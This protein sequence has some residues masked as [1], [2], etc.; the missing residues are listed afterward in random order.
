MNE[1]LEAY[2]NMQLKPLYRE[3][4]AEK[5]FIKEVTVHTL[6]SKNRSFKTE[7]LPVVKEFTKKF[8]QLE[9]KALN[10]VVK[11]CEVL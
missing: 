8:I 11:D 5:L 1:I 10:L 3:F 6:L 4:L 9:K 2:K 7:H